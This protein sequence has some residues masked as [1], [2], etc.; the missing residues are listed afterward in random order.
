MDKAKLRL[1]TLPQL[2]VALFDRLVAT[3]NIG[4]A[5]GIWTV[6]DVEE[7]LLSLKVAVVRRVDLGHEVLE[8]G[9]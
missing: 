4:Q 2:W 7:G 3:I 9:R 8:D 6:K 1:Q 5:H